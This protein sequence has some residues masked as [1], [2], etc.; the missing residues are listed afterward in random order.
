MTPFYFHLVNVFLHCVVTALLMHTCEQCV[1]EDSNFSFLTAL[2]FSVHPI[3][4][5]AV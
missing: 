3:H 4:T 1:F 2:L 5:E